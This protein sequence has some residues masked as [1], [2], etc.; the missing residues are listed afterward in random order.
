VTTWK[1]IEGPH[2]E[3]KRE[4]MREEPQWRDLA[5]MLR[6]DCQDFDPRSQKDRDGFDSFD[7]TP[8]YALDNFVGGIFGEATNPADRWFEL[9]IDDENLMKFAPVKQWLWDA[10]SVIY[11]SLSPAVSQFYSEA[12]AWIADMGAFGDSFMW[13][14]EYVGEN[15]LIERAIPIGEMFKD[16]DAAGM[17]NRLHREFMLT[18]RRAKYW[19]RDR[20]P[21]MRDDE[22]AMFVHAVYPN[23]DFRP[24]ALGP[25]GMR[26]LSCYVSPDKRDFSV[27]GGYHELPGHELQWNKRSGRSW[28]T[29][30][31][32]NA[33][34]DMRMA[35]EMQ[36]SN[37]TAMQFDAEPMFLVQ[38]ED[39]MTA[40]DI[41]PHSVIYGGVNEQGKDQVRTLA[42]GENLHFPL[43]GIEQVRSAIREAFYFG[44]MQLVSR[45][46]MTATEFLGFKEEKLKLLAPNLVRIHRGLAGF[47]GRR[48]GILARA[49]QLPP[50]PPELA[51]KGINVNF[52][53]PFAKVQKAA[54]A[55]GVIQYWQGLGQIFAATGEHDIFDNG[56][57]DASARILHD[58]LSGVPEIQRDPRDIAARRQARAQQVAQQQQLEQAAQGASIVADVS[59]AAQAMTLS[60]KRGQAA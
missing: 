12:P 2:Q 16:V 50:M 10:A 32:H 60:Q 14:E 30:P 3:M 40:A 21:N 38:N 35:D 22:Q 20:A 26:Y 18:G 11:A 17:T 58:A 28:A 15:R 56:D 43:A 19:W 27:V 31:G 5:R 7:S 34:A 29:G 45:P 53:S 47:I 39:I 54:K 13:Q 9:G 41:A 55:R 42:R 4:R 51:N 33:L 52:V 44:I 24:R 25:R 59:H 1:E 37:L 48:A 23:P 46:Q 49:S 57:Q 36:R 8:L 6:P